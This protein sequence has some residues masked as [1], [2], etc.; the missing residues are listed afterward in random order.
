MSAHDNA[1]PKGGAS[2]SR[3]LGGNGAEITRRFTSTQQLLARREMARAAIASTR[4]I[5][6]ATDASLFQ[7]LCDLDTLRIEPDTADA[8]HDSIL[9]GLPC[10]ECESGRQE[11]IRETVRRWESADACNRRGPR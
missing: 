6:R 3:L 5:L 1:A 11:F 4:A 2:R 7:L 8:Q 9:L 10:P